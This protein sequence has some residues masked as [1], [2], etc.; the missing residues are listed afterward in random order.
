M[1]LDEALARDIGREV[2]G[3]KTVLKKSDLQGKFSRGR[4]SESAQTAAV[5]ASYFAAMGASLGQGRGF[6]AEDEYRARQVIILGDSLARSLFPEGGPVGKSL[7]ATIGERSESFEVIGVLAEKEPFFM[8]NWNQTAYIPFATASRRLSGL[9]EPG[10]F[11]VVATGRD[12]VLALGDALEAY[13]LARTG[14]PEA[15]NV[16][17]PKKWAEQDEKMTGTISLILSGIA[18]I[19]LLVGGIGVMNIMLVSVTE[20]RREIGLRKALGATKADLRRQFLVEASILTLAGGI[21]GLGLGFL[22]SYFAVQ[23]FHWRFTAS[24]GTAA[25]AF[26]VSVATGLFSGIYP[27]IRAAR[28]DPIEALASE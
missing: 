16:I 9:V 23:A 20:R 19:S 21:L 7:Q 26:G 12:K 27:A 8:D 13:L 10:L 1:R 2:P 15:F 22:V 6:S 17:S 24:L 14:S 28:L 3:V 5:E 25:L 4:L 11:T 18:A